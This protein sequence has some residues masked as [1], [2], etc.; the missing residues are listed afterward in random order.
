MMFMSS[1]MW[2]TT[3]FQLVL[4]FA[5]L[6]EILSFQIAWAIVNTITPIANFSAGSQPTTR[7]FHSI[8]QRKRLRQTKPAA[9]KSQF[10]ILFDIWQPVTGGEHMSFCVTTVW[11]KMAPVG[12]G[13]SCWLGPVFV[14]SFLCS[15]LLSKQ[16]HP[17]LHKFA[18]D[19]GRPRFNAA[20]RADEIP[21]I[22][23][24]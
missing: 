23:H 16:D 18:P 21:C 2:T 12:K 1:L 22:F 13:D 11:A 15:I 24:G 8:S 9:V 19:I 20:P 4:W 10:Q 7:A 5:K 6:Q 17:L 14:G 3:Q